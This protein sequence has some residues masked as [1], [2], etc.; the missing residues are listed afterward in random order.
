MAVDGM[1]ARLHGLTTI[2][3]DR[4]KGELGI[5]GPRRDRDASDTFLAKC[6]CQPVSDD[7]L[8]TFL[9]ELE[10]VMLRQAMVYT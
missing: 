9:L 8:D 6:G 1:L 10:G 4:A 7:D 2:P 5:L 3:V